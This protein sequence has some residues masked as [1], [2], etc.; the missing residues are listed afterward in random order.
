MDAS[1]PSTSKGITTKKT[2]KDDLFNQP[3]VN[4]EPLAKPLADRKRKTAVVE[5]KAKPSQK[6]RGRKKK[7]GPIKR[8]TNK[9]A[10]RLPFESNTEL[11]DPPKSMVAEESI[12]IP[13]KLKTIFR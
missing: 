12:S 9:Q 2:I 8:C 3:T 13:G 7:R 1:Q 10:T 11:P 5:T 6:K 4:I